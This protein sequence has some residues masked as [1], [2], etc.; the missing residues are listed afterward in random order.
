MFLLSAWA[1]RVREEWTHHMGYPVMP[2]AELKRLCRV[3]LNLPLPELGLWTKAFTECE[4]CQSNN[5]H[6]S[7][8]AQK[9]CILAGILLPPN[10]DRILPAWL[11]LHSAIVPQLK[12]HIPLQELTIH[13]LSSNCVNVYIYREMALAVLTS[14]NFL[15]VTLPV[16]TCTW[17]SLECLSWEASVVFCWRRAFNSGISHVLFTSRGHIL[18]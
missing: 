16:I 17:Q 1:E 5:F 11:Q 3:R 14:E 10:V 6:K 13:C 4:A 15:S 8:K 18:A 12:T 7:F 9:E 2:N